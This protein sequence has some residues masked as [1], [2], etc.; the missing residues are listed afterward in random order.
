MRL[1][2]CICVTECITRARALGWALARNKVFAAIRTSDS[3]GAGAML[4]GSSEAKG[5]SQY[6]AI[7]VNGVGQRAK[8][9]SQPAAQQLVETCIEP[10]AHKHTHTHAHTCAR[11][12]SPATLRRLRASQ[13]AC[14]AKFASHAFMS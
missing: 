1:V 12:L 7:Q 6:T 11:A 3:V 5:F 13:V 9:A 4:T 14:D 8:P 10:N 2:A